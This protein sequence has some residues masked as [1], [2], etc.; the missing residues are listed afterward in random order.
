MN[1][2]EALQAGL[3]VLTAVGIDG[4]V[5]TISAANPQAF[6]LTIKKKICLAEQC[7]FRQ[8]WAEL[9][10]GTPYENT[11]VVLLTD[12]M[13]LSVVDQKDL[14]RFVQPTN[15]GLRGCDSPH[16]PFRNI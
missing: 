4:E 10:K 16:G 2:H 1:R 3:G 7:A 6:V 12:G 13:Q 8:Q 5:A 14:P 15:D 11:P 9:F